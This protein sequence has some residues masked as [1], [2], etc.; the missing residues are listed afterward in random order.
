MQTQFSDQ[1]GL[2]NTVVIPQSTQMAI[3]P[4]GFGA[5]RHAESKM[6]RSSRPTG[7]T[8]LAKQM[9]TRTAMNDITFG[10]IKVTV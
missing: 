3:S 8:A 10:A 6:G 9:R 7:T 2:L 4:Q 5:K 1:Q